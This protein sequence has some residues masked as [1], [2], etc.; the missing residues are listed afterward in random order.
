MI[1]QKFREKARAADGCLNVMVGS[2]QTRK[3]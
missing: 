2:V 3:E 1:I